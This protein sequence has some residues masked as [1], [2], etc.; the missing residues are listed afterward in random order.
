MT[1]NC[2]RA[3]VLALLGIVLGSCVSMHSDSGKDYSLQSIDIATLVRW[4]DAQRL[5]RM[6][7]LRNQDASE[8]R[9]LFKAT[10]Q[11]ANRV[12]PELLGEWG[13]R[14]LVISELPGVPG[15]LSISEQRRNPRGWGVWVVQASGAPGLM[16][17]APHSDTDLNTGIIAAQWAQQP[18]VA[19]TMWNTVPRSAGGARGTSSDLARVSPSLFTIAAEEFVSAFPKSRVVQLHG[20]RE[21]GL[22]DEPRTVFDAI[23]SSGAPDG[24][25]A[26]RH[27]A[28]CLRTLGLNPAVY[29]IDVQILGGTKNATGLAV[30][31]TQSAGFMHLELSA[32]LRQ[33]MATDLA[34]SLSVYKCVS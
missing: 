27:T 16:L 33:R 18:G 26:I 34:F 13:G 10:F 24:S 31:A 20:M 9:A 19:M 21:D 7:P 30:R 2:R 6:R 8:L 17:Q 15:M 12:G 25:D 22:E 11:S 1:S 3:A 5:A 4:L 23:L 29:G 28:S 14:H 32:S